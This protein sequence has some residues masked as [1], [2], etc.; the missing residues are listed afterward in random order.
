[1]N[2]PYC[3]ISD[4]EMEVIF[5]NNLVLFMQ[6]ERYQGALKHSG[7]IIPVQVPVQVVIWNNSKPY[8]AR[9]LTLRWMA[10]LTLTIQLF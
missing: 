3:P 2:C 10:L 4:P 6:N 5:E 8:C 1:M 9:T 7:A